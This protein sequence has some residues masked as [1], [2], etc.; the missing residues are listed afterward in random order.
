M[1]GLRRREDTHRAEGPEQQPSTKTTAWSH[2]TSLGARAG[3]VIL[4]AALVIGP[5]TA[6]YAAMRMRA[7]ESQIDQVAAALSSGSDFNPEQH[8]EVSQIGAATV[9][10]WLSATRDDHEWLASLA[11]VEPTELP[12]SP[13]NYRSP[14]VASITATTDQIWT[15]TVAVSIE[16]QL[17]E[18]ASTWSRTYFEV[19]VVQTTDGSLAALTLP[20]PVGAPAAAAAPALPFTHQLAPSHELSATVA[21]FLAALLTSDGE[22]DRYVA[23]GAQIVPIAAGS[24]SAIGQTE[25]LASAPEEDLTAGEDGQNTAVLVHVPVERTDGEPMPATYVLDLTTRS[26]R[27]EISGIRAADSLA[28]E[29]EGAE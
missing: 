8:T 1:M 29:T 9:E 24:Y 5:L 19:P 22:V 27:W 28:V 26:G 13:V 2:G 18:D 17:D 12:T 20:A 25:V 16:R 4:L 14:M 10:A 15:V 7:T 11:S 6:G 23:P 3:Y 21:A